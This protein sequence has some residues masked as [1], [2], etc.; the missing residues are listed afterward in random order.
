[1]VARRTRRPRSSDNV[2][3]I[4]EFDYGALPLVNVLTYRGIL[5]KVV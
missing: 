4:R 5:R 2:V 3:M 1:M